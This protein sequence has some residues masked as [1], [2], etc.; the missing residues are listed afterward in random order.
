M[1]DLESS[2]GLAGARRHDE[3]D[4][5]FAVCHSFNGSVYGVSLIVARRIAAVFVIVRRSDDFF[6]L[7]RF[8]AFRG[9][10]ATP[11]LFG[12]REFVHAQ[13]AY[14]AGGEI[15]LGETFSV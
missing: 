10:E 5:V 6:G 15:M 3:K 4:S 8:Y 11:Q 9:A 14:L 1:Y 13:A 12:G 7:L 2:I